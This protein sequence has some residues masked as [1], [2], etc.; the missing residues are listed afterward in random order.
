MDVSVDVSARD[1]TNSSGDHMAKSHCVMAMSS[2][3]STGMHYYAWREST[4][5]LFS[6]DPAW[7]GISISHSN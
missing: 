7:F 5:A 4:T 2:N 6:S 1:I 3:G